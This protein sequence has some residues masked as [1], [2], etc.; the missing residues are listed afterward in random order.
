MPAAARAELLVCNVCHG[1]HTARSTTR[2]RRHPH[3]CFRFPQVPEGMTADRF[4][5]IFGTHV[6]MVDAAFSAAAEDARAHAPREERLAYLHHL[7]MQ[8]LDDVNAQAVQRTGL[9]EEV[10]SVRGGG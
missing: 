3:A 6:E 10:F 8:R 2:F 1:G 5:E 9:T 7:V 4:V